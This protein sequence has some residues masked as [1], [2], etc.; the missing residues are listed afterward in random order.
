LNIL[1]KK[2]L[3]KKENGKKAVLFVSSN[4]ER[5]AEERRGGRT[6]GDGKQLW[7]AG[8]STATWPP[9]MWSWPLGGASWPPR[10]SPPLST[11]PVPSLPSTSPSPT[12]VPSSVRAPIAYYLFLSY[13]YFYFLLILVLIYENNNNNKIVQ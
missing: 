8:L 12:W 9:S 1:K 5:W 2:I 3:V 13:S 4:K 11:R 7:A 6:G 10:W